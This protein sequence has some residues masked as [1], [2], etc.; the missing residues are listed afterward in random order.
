MDSYTL[1]WIQ[2][3]IWM[4]LEEKL[5]C[6]LER[7]LGMENSP[8]FGLLS[9]SAI[10]KRSTKRKKLF[11]FFCPGVLCGKTAVSS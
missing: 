5:N 2:K 10:L 11:N 6:C 4:I 7:L 9:L 1:W 3:I 8:I